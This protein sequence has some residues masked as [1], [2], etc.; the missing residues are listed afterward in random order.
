M[1]TAVSIPLRRAALYLFLRHQR[2]RPAEHQR[3]PAQRCEEE[4]NRPLH[5]GA[6]EELPIDSTIDQEIKP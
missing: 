2:A 3:L 4:H 1:T 5:I 6:D